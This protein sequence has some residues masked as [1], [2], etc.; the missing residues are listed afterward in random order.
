MAA[1]TE[2]A[3]QACR[4][5]V[6]MIRA[7]GDAWNGA[8]TWREAWQA[9]A[10]GAAVVLLKLEPIAGSVVL[11]TFAALSGAGWVAA[12]AR[13]RRIEMATDGEPEVV[14]MLVDEREG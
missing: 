9:L 12:R 11:A 13:R 4:Q 6:A 7:T 5:V 2:R 3:E 1:D 14:A 8:E 10:I